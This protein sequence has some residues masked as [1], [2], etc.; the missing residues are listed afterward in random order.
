[1]ILRFK[2]SEEYEK[3]IG[4]F[5]VNDKVMAYLIPFK[6]DSGTEY[7]YIHFSVQDGECLNLNTIAEIDYELPFESRFKAFEWKIDHFDGKSIEGDFYL[8]FL[9]E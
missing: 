3:C 4:S 6:G 8:I 2:K 9:F 5:E 7:L 1:M